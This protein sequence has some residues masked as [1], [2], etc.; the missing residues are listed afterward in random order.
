[1]RYGKLALGVLLAIVGLFGAI[2]AVSGGIWYAQSCPGTSGMFLP[3]VCSDDLRETLLWAAVAVVTGVGAILS[4][5]FRSR[6][7]ISHRAA[8]PL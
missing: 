8:Q 6:P 7:W 1:M 3:R 5:R 2:G 4:L